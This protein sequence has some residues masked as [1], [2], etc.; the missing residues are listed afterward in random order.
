MFEAVNRAL[1]IWLSPPSDLSGAA[2]FWL[3]ALAQWPVFA[4]P[5]LLAML[6]LV[7]STEDREAAVLAAVSGCVALL[8]AHVASTIVV[9][10]RPFMDG[11][12]QN[13]LD[14]VR[15][16]SFPSDHATLFF[17]LTG[18]F[19]LRPALLVPR[20]WTGLAIGGIAVGLARVALGAHY[21]FDVLGAIAIGLIAA[22]IVVETPVAVLAAA[23]ASLGERFRSLATSSTRSR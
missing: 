20:L 4:L 19:L 1:F 10:P 12:Q 13:F 18:S 16:S 5:L 2:L 15:D 9:H 22:A 6:W 8:V 14:H 7:G 3:R 17:G 23:L 21:P 11:L